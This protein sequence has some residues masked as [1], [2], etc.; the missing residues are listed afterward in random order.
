[1]GWKWVNGWAYY[2]RSDCEYGPVRSEYIGGREDAVF[3]GQLYEIGRQGREAER[4]NAPWE[5]QCL[6][7]NLYEFTPEFAEVV[8]C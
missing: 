5:P 6:F 7:M 2:Y 1:M 8:R 3:L 4:T